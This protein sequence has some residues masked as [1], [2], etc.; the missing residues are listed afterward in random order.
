MQCQNLIWCVFKMLANV[1]SLLQWIE[2]VL[3]NLQE[4]TNINFANL[5]FGQ[6]SASCTEIEFW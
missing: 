5:D 4:T 3:T 1:V 2:N 6:P